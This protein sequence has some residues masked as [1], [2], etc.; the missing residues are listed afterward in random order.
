MTMALSGIMT[1]TACAEKEY[2]PDNDV[3]AVK[4]KLDVRGMAQGGQGPGIA[5]IEDEYRIG[6][7]TVYRFSEGLLKEIIRPVSMAENEYSISVSAMEGRLYVAANASGIG[8][9]DM[10]SPD[11]CTEQQFKGIEAASEALVNDGIVMAGVTDIGGNSV[12]VKM[13]RSVARI[14]VASYERDVQVLGVQIDGLSDTGKVFPQDGGFS[15]SYDSGTV[16]SA[17]WSESPL[18]KGTRT[19]AYVPEQSGNRAEATVTISSGEGTHKLRSVLP[20]LLKR[21]TVY[22]LGIHGT[23][24]QAS[25]TVTEG[26]WSSSDSEETVPVYG[27]LVD[28]DLSV[29]A[30]GVRVSDSR[31]TVY[32]SHTEKSFTLAIAAHPGATVSVDGTVE[33]VGIESAVHRHTDLEHVATLDVSTGFRLPGSRQERIYVDVY[34]EDVLEGRVVLVFEANPVRLGGMLALDADGVC[35]FGRYVDGDLGTVTVPPDKVLDFEYDEGESRWMKYE[36]E[37]ASSGERTYRIIGGWKPNDPKADGRTQEGRIVISS[38]DGSEREA[39]TVR[40]VNAGLPVVQ[41]GETWWARYNLRG[42]VKDIGAQIAHEDGPSADS[43]QFGWLQTLPDDALLG[44]MGDQ[45]QA[46]NQDGLPLKHDGTGYYYEGMV[47]YPGNFGLVDPA[48][49]A[50]DGYRIPSYDDYAF[51]VPSDDYNLGGVG[52]RS[53]RNRTGET[54]TVQISEREVSFLGH[55]YG[56]VAFYDFEYGGNHLVLYGLGHQWNLTTGNVAKMNLLLATWGDEGRTWALEGYASTDR[57]GQNWLKYAWNNTTKTRLVRC[58][59]TPVEYI[60]D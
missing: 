13:T 38:P 35:D 14:D 19:L 7:V 6:D 20:S 33:G 43:D 8:I 37:V 5:G 49:M 31:D 44:I 32:V 50:P 34:H 22:T 15:A 21:N 16:V 25:L 4:M 56:T 55:D 23:G 42:N 10:V 27:G 11:V 30:S 41:I 26:G 9:E 12:N 54:I 39:Y 29:L 40:R 48:T 36:E 52:S 51:L 46:G 45:Y 47:Q 18:E 53:Y 57:P 17:D 60:Y 1:V 2:S 59:K 24:A 3:N 58:V 28:V